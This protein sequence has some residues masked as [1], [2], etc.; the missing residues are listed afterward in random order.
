MQE[1][2]RLIDRVRYIK[3]HLGSDLRG[4]KQNKLNDQV[5]SIPLCSLGLT[6]KLNIQNIC[7]NINEYIESGLFRRQYLLTAAACDMVTRQ[8]TALLTRRNRSQMV[9]VRTLLDQVC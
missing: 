4:H 5:Y 3:I 2:L 8:C 1:Q 9:P 6:V 7:R